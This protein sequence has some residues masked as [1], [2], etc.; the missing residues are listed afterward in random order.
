MKGRKELMGQI[1]TVVQQE[2]SPRPVP[3]PLEALDSFLT[4]LHGVNCRQSH[5]TQVCISVS[6]LGSTPGA[7]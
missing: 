7:T 6:P 2:H 4:L 1:G 3:H 5:L